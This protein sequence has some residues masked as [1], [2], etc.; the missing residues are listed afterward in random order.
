MF[1]CI[2]AFTSIW[3]SE[4]KEKAIFTVGQWFE[5]SLDFPVRDFK[6]MTHCNLGEKKNG[7]CFRTTFARDILLDMGFL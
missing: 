6:R 4:K 1:F 7:G 2:Y 3:N 5:I